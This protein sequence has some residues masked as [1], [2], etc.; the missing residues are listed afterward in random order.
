[1][2]VERA[3]T[4]WYLQRQTILNEIV[5]LEQQMAELQQQEALVKQTVAEETQVTLA[6][7]AHEANDTSVQVTETTAFERNGE[8]TEV[9]EIVQDSEITVA[10]VEQSMAE[11]MNLS[12]SLRR[13]SLSIKRIMSASVPAPSPQMTELLKQ[14]QQVHAKLLQLGP[15]PR[16]MMG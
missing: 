11:I 9:T 4:R 8:M 2:G 5:Q 12:M 15:C 14:L 6:E 13:V 7:A 16:P 3:V 10:F 1:M